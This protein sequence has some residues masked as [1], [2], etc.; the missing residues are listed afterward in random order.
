M[1]FQMESGIWRLQLVK[2]C[3]LKYWRRGKEKSLRYQ[4]IKVLKRKKNV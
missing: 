4:D 2:N 1:R 3:F